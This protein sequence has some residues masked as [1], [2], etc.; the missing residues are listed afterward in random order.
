MVGIGRF[1]CYR[2]GVFKVEGVPK[3]EAGFTR[4]ALEKDGWFIYYS[5]VV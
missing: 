1:Y 3:E 5:V 2:Q 4:V